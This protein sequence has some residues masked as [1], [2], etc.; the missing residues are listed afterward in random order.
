MKAVI[1]DD[2]IKARE[3]LEYLIKNFCPDVEVIASVS[4]ISDG[5]VA[6]RTNK[7]DLVFL[8]IEMP[9]GNGFELLDKF[10]VITFNLIF[11][12]A[13]EHYALQA[14]KSEAIDYLLKPIDIDELINAV[15]KVCETKNTNLTFPGENIEKLALP[16]RD[17][18]VFLKLK[19]ISRIESDGSYT[20]FF[21]ITNEKFVVSKNIAEFER[22]LDGSCFFRCHKS[23]II[24]IN[25]V[26][27]FLRT[28]GY[29]V[30]ME[31]GSQV[32]VSRR[33]KELFLKQMQGN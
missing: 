29:F 24:N 31:D 12:S 30:E 16:M 4:S 13:Y 28:D 15:A 32:E 1:I 5:E 10:K 19:E 8:D 6:I 9:H 17:G 7:T 18:Y 33:K 22:I 23:H 2:E 11:I 14:I 21:T 27:K 3:N 25:F 26:K 20:T